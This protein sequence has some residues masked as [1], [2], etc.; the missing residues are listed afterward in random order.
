[1]RMLPFCVPIAQSIEELKHYI[2]DRFSSVFN[3]VFGPLF[4]LL[5]NTIV[6]ISLR[7]IFRSRV[8]PPPKSRA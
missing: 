8:D 7:H 2:F 6:D 1:M 5:Y 3:T 4:R